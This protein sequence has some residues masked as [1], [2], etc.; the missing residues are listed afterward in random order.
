MEAD[1][2]ACPWCGET[3]LAVAKKC[4]HCG[5]FLTD[6]R[7][8]SAEQTTSPEEDLD[9][10]EGWLPT[11]SGGGDPL[12]VC[13]AH[14]RSSVCPDCGRAPAAA[15]P[16]G[17]CLS[18]DQLHGRGVPSFKPSD[19]SR[20]LGAAAAGTAIPLKNGVP[21]CAR[22]GGTSF[23]PR[24]KTSTKVVFGVASLAARP[25]HVECVTCGALYDRS[26][27]R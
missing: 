15:P 27:S 19:R 8:D 18:A 14:G 3:I 10:P 7:S 5:E 26:I 13:S 17:A 9:L 24:R 21:T 16:P 2:K 6:G 12:W 4:K 1:E 25:H 22:C 11:K 20:K 23:V